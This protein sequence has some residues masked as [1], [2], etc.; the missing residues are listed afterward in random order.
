MTNPIL[1]ELHAVREQLLH[2]AGGTL[3]GLVESLQQGVPS[4][5]KAAGQIDSAVPIDNEQAAVGRPPLP[6]GTTWPIGR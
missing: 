5:T 1:D 2:E 4:A 6:T 3:H